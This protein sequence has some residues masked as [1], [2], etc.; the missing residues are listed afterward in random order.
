MQQCHRVELY[1]YLLEQH[2]QPTGQQQRKSSQHK[3]G[4]LQT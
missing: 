2:P 3:N 1:E 4:Q